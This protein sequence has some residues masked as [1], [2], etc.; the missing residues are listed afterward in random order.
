[1]AG[2]VI[3]KITAG[4]GSVNLLSNSAFFVCFTDAGV[5]QKEARCVDAGIDNFAPIEGMTIKVLFYSGNT[6]T[7]P[8]LTLKNQSGSRQLLGP[9]NIYSRQN[10]TPSQDNRQWSA[11]T[12]V[13]FSYVATT[14]GS[15]GSDHYWVSDWN[16]SVQPSS[17]AA[18][19]VTGSGTVTAGNS[20][21]YA[22]ADHSH[23]LTKTAVTAALG[24]TPADS[25]VAGTSVG[26]VTPADVT[27]TISN[28]TYGS[29]NLAARADHNHYISKTTIT[30]A[31]GYTPPQTNT[32]YS[33]ATTVSTVATASVVGT[34]TAYARQDHVHDISKA[35]ITTAIGYVP[36]KISD[37]V[38]A[39]MVKISGEDYKLSIVSNSV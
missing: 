7:T 22:R 24:Y 29:S 10:I 19:T 12:I 23:L 15:S 27:P 38:S 21:N 8:T 2:Q 30:T 1:M 33:A 13:T 16:T 18:A 32:T 14:W 9:L 11:G 31:L 35:T 6:T 5:A 25:A 4:D 37:T 3:S 34:S 17:V 26:S 39:S 36:A 28:L 20:L